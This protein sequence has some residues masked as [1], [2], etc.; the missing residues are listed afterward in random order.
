MSFL[1][2]KKLEESLKRTLSLSLGVQKG[3]RFGSL[4]EYF[5]RRG[6][7]PGLE[8]AVWRA[9]Q[10]CTLKH[11]EVSFWGSCNLQHSVEV[12]FARVC[13]LK[14][15]FGGVCSLQHSVEA[16]S[17]SSFQLFKWALQRVT[18]SLGFAA[19][20]MTLAQLSFWGLFKSQVFLKIC[21]ISSMHCAPCSGHG[22][23]QLLGE[24]LWLLGVGLGDAWVA[25]RPPCSGLDSLA[26]WSWKLG[27]K[28]ATF[29][30]KAW[31]L[32]CSLETTIS[33]LKECL[34]AVKALATSS[35]WHLLQTGLALQG[36]CRCLCRLKLGYILV[37]LLFAAARIA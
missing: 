32:A 27:K 11:F 20:W 37:S 2:C 4:K 30:F 8:L 23:Q 18:F 19:P 33:S 31:R 7:S 24:D 28:S 22:F 13:S 36:L 6:W 9:L 16:C 26:G 21:F 1:D 34:K 25:S 3:S 29:F 12:C 10:G 35:S 15:G 17:N 5:V 14:N